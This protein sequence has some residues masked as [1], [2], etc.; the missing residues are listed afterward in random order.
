MRAVTET[1]DVALSLSDLLDKRRHANAAY[2]LGNLDTANAFRVLLY[3]T[4]VDGNRKAD[5]ELRNTVLVVATLLVKRKEN[6][7][8]FL[9]S[10]CVMHAPV[11]CYDLLYF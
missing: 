5:K 4:L 11:T 7:A 3:R 2:V 9:E 1:S 6:R 10:G 8:V